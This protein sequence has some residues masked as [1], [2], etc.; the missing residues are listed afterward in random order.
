MAVGKLAEKSNRENK[1]K[2]I[3]RGKSSAHVGHATFTWNASYKLQTRGHPMRCRQPTLQMQTK[4]KSQGFKSPAD[5]RSTTL[6][7]FTSTTNPFKS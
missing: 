7:P 4:M 2:P 6:F 3:C 1:D 5:R